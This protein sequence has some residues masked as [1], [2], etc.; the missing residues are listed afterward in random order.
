VL[1]EAVEAGVAA[2]LHGGADPAGGR[3]L[4]GEDV[5]PHDPIET[6]AA[7]PLADDLKSE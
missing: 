2:F 4:A 5:E 3:P 1:E 6:E 7:R